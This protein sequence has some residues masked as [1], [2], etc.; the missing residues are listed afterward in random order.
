[1]QIDQGGD[2][3]LGLDAPDLVAQPGAHLGV[4]GGEGFVEQEHAGPRHEGTREGD[5]LLLP[6]AELVGVALA[7]LAEAHQVQRLLGPAAAILRRDLAHPQPELDVLHHGQVW[8][9][10]VLLEHHAEVT[11]IGR[12]TGHVLVRDVDGARGDLLEAGEA[13]ERGGLAAA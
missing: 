13:P 10:G 3:Q 7:V 11:P 2:A 12:D 8:E 9:E 1:M 5:P 6:A 4:E